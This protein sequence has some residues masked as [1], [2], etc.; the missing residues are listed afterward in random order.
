L[1]AIHPDIQS[2]VR[3]EVRNALPGD[4]SHSAKASTGLSERLEALPYLNA[5][6]NETLR[7][8]PT[9]PIV[10]RTAIRDTRIGDTIVPKD[11]QILIAPAAINRSYDLWGTDADEFRPER[12][13]DKK[14]DGQLKPNNHGSAS[15]NYSYL[16]F[17]H[18]PRSCIGQGFAK[19]EL[20]VL[21]AT[22]VKKFE[23]EMNNPNDKVVAAG[24]V[25]VKPQ[26]GLNLRV[27][28]LDG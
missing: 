23:F 1:L 16:T 14:A 21:V 8:Y 26:H 9:V 7:L 13:I 19:A 11:T 5:V 28:I 18:G 12:W 15:S 20:R 17:L 4:V 22:W 10:L 27:K 2:R 25:T 6:C 3:T 24:V